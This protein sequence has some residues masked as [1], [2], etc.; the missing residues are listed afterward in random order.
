MSSLGGP[1]EHIWDIARQS[2]GRI[3][4]VGEARFPGAGGD[5]FALA[6]YTSTG[7]LDNTFGGDGVVVS[8]LAAGENRDNALAVA[9]QPDGKIV[10]AGGIRMGAGNTNNDMVVAR[11]NA[12]GT[13]DSSFGGDGVVT[14]AV[15]PGTRQ[16]AA[17]GVAIQPDGKIVV[18]G[19]A[20]MGP[21]AGRH[22]FAFV[23]YNADGTLDATFGGDGIVTTAVAVGDGFD[24]AWALTLLP[25][26]KILGVGNALMASGLFEIALA[27]YNPDGSLDATFDGD[28]IATAPLEEGDADVWAVVIDDLGRIIVAGDAVGA[29]FFDSWVARFD[30]SGMLDSSFGDEGIVV[31]P[32]APDGGYDAFYEVGL[33]KTG[34][35]VAS[36]ECDQP[37]TGTDVC[38]ARFKSG[39]D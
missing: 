17:I 22:N 21:G 2:D 24:T 37:I 16:D 9:L 25:E 13:L 10:A 27:R 12:E 14:T 3:V 39:D 23:R 34:K 20:D 18:G 31:T 4:A 28:G 38:I 33:D 36:G 5:N 19:Q 29:D 32:T 15:A 1:D 26:G 6:R 11:Y 8:A 30:S 35:I 7:A